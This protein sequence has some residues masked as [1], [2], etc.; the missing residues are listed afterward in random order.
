[1]H[2]ERSAAANDVL[3]VSRPQ[4]A[5]DADMVRHGATSDGYIAC[6]RL[7]DARDE[8]PFALAHLDAGPFRGFLPVSLAT[9]DD[10]KAKRW[11]RKCE[12]VLRLHDV[13]LPSRQSPAWIAVGILELDILE[14]D[15]RTGSTAMA[16]EAIPP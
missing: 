16:G 15:L 1:M 9:S 13:W 5:L 6:H 7:Y 3:L 12:R 14:S 4:T 10:V 11:D 2:A 8:H